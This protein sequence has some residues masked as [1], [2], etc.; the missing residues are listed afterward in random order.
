M[1]LTVEELKKHMTTD[2]EDAVLEAKLSALELLVRAYTHNNFQQRAVRRMADIAGGTIIMESNPFKVGD[3]VQVTES[4]FNEGLYTVTAIEDSAITIKEDT[5]DEDDVLVTRVVY[6]MDVK[7]GVVNLMKW[8]LERREKVGVSSETISRH[9]VTYESMTDDNS[10]MGYPKM[11]MGFL[12][13]YIR[14]RFG[15][16]VRL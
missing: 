15:Q 5:F 12:K 11:L 13:P 2:E 16:G 7:M 1:L 9:S 4:D 6:P 14:A 8:E 10:I 3:T